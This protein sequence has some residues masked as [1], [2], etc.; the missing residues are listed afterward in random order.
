MHALLSAYSILRFLGRW[1]ALFTFVRTWSEVRPARAG[2]RRGQHSLRSMVRAGLTRPS[3]LPR[4]A[5]VAV[6]IQHL[7]AGSVSTHSCVLALCASALGDR[8][9]CP[10]WLRFPSGLL[11]ACIVGH[12]P[13]SERSSP[14]R[15]A[16]RCAPSAPCAAGASHWALGSGSTTVCLGFAVSDHLSCPLFSNILLRPV[17]K[18][19]G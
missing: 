7:G 17:K 15:S 2:L 5:R 1:A 13:S 19:R 8:A 6:C 12:A 3:R 16:A 18:K 11:G 14:V 4:F 9:S 10:C